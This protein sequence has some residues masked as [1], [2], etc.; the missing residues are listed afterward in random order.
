MGENYSILINKNIFFL[1]EFF[2][3]FFEKRVDKN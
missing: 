2:G 3:A 1:L